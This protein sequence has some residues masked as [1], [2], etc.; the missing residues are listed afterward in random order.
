M[1]K[2]LELARAKINLT[3]HVTG[4]RADG[5]HLLDS[6]VVFADFGDEI[7][8]QIS[9]QP[10]LELCGPFAAFL[11]AND[12]NLVMR[13][14]GLMDETAALKLDKRLPVSSGIGGGSSDA[15]ATLRLL[16]RL[17]GKPLPPRGALMRLGADVPVCLAQNAVRM[18]GAGDI[19]TPLLPLPRVWVVLLHPGVAVSTPEVFTRLTK[20]ENPAMPHIIPRFSDAADL[21]AFVRLQRNDLEA[22]ARALAPQIAS[23]QEALRKQSG[24]LLARMSGSGATC[25]GLFSSQESARKAAQTITKT[26]PPTWWCVAA[27]VLREAKSEN[28]PQV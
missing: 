3:L 1:A 24:C 23:A 19:L 4:Q 13:A 26:A 7:S 8:G 12:D 18:Q 21:A 15:A 22:P 17:S 16:N 14:A 11:N 25:F 9:A 2:T 27:P 10:S 20:K 28:I 5:Y 6:L